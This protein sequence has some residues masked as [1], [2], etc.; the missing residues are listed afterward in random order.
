[1][2][3]DPKSSQHPHLCCMLGKQLEYPKKPQHFYLYCVG[4]VGEEKYHV[5]P[6]SHSILFSYLLCEMGGKWER[7][8]VGPNNHSILIFRV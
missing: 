4:L 5:D 2:M 1:M 6:N 8:L 7:Q 3:L